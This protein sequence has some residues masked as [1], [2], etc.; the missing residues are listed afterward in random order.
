VC[1]LYGVR[2]QGR[3]DPASR[4]GGR[5][6][7]LHAVSGGA[8]GRIEHAEKIK[9]PLERQHH[10]EALCGQSFAQTVQYGAEVIARGRL[11]KGEGAVVF[12]G[13][14]RGLGLDQCRATGSGATQQVGRERR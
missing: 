7:R 9:G 12:D 11:A 6:Y 2:P 13:P 4:M 8:L 5:T 1:P 10:Q 14:R 3:D